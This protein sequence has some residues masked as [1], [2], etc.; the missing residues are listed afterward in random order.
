MDHVIIQNGQVFHRG[1]FRPLNLVVSQGLIQLI[2]PYAVDVLSYP[3]GTQVIDAQ[4]QYVMPGFIDIHTH[5][6]YGVDVNNAKPDDLKRLATAFGQNG[7]TSCLL[8]IVTD[9][10][11]NTQATIQHYL[12]AKDSLEPAAANLLG[13]HLEGPFLSVEYKGSMPE[14]LLI[15]YNHQL[16]KDYQALSENN[17]RYITVAP[18]VTGVL[19]HIP[20][21]VSLGIKVSLGHSSASYDTARE[22]IAGGAQVCTHTFNAMKLFHQHDP[23]I[24]AAMLEDET[25]FCELI[26]DGRHVVEGGV[27]MLLAAKGNGRVVG[28]TDSI[29]A[30]GLPNGQ[31][32]LGVNEIVVKDGDAKL[33]NAD[34]RAGSTLTMIQALSNFV[35][36]TGK[37]VAEIVPILTENPARAIG[38]DHEIGFI[39]VGYRGD[40]NIVSPYDLSLTQTLIAG[41]IIHPIKP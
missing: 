3:P 13:L 25:V 16:V 20:D 37:S 8:S 23:A 21:L 40:L 4:G 27:R 29:M 39:E 30:A 24:F 36:F 15:A 18:E 35:S 41:Q 1:K 26:C 22:A 7:T 9:T 2:T 12:K 38:F 34:V 28:I 32:K 33:A 19:E 10:V 14:H 11:E 17:I 31:Y 6:G 5:G